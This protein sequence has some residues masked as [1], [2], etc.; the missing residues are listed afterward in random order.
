MAIDERTPFPLPGGRRRVLLHRR[1]TIAVCA[2]ARHLGLRYREY[3]W[4]KG[5]RS[6]RVIE[7]SKRAVIS[8][9]DSAAGRHR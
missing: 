2:V 8:A 6:A 7:I 4:R 5:D 9:T 3:D 1:S